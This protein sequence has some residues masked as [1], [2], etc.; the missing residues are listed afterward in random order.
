MVL[1]GGCL[2]TQIP[3]YKALV[4][5]GQWISRGVISDEGSLAVHVVSST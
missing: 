5:G 1:G 2:G 4:I 3:E